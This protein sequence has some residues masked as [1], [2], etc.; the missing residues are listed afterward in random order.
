MNFGFYY[1]RI[2][3]GNEARGERYRVLFEQLG[4]LGFERGKG[5]TLGV[6]MVLRSYNDRKKLKSWQSLS[7]GE[8]FGDD[9]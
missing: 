8:G 4:N 1:N 6:L 9:V 2:F 7:A 3:I 5:V